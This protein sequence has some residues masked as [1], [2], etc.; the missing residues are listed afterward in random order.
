MGAKSAQHRDF[1]EDTAIKIDLEV[2]RLVDESYA[3]AKTI[4]ENNRQVLIDIAHALLEREVLDAHEVQTLIEGK[5]L[6][7]RVSPNSHDDQG[8]VQQVLKP[9]PSRQPQ[10]G[11]APGGRPSPA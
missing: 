9:E 3:A 8:G 4:L 2:R 1:S 7:A 6:P 5:E 11:L 10:P